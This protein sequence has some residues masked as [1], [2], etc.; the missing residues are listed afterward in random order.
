[1]PS[2][3]RF[4]FEIVQRSKGYDLYGAANAPDRMA[5]F[6]ELRGPNLARLLD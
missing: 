2:D 3:D 6:A 1:M 4:F 5:A